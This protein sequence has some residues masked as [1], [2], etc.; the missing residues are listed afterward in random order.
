G[1]W[2]DAVEQR[3]ED[4]AWDG[5]PAVGNEQ[6]WRPATQRLSFRQQLELRADGKQLYERSRQRRLRRRR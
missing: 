1:A 2:A 5:M 4:M 6:F 3:L